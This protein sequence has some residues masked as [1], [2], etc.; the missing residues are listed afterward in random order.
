VPAGSI[1]E[2]GRQARC[3]GCGHG[4]HAFAPLDLGAAAAQPRPAPAGTDPAPRPDTSADAMAPGA[5]EEAHGPAAPA[6]AAPGRRRQFAE[7]RG[8]LDDV[9]S[10]DDAAPP[11]AKG[12]AR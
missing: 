1:G 12:D 7:I 9:Q 6:G 2:N 10:G 4:W 11:A 3:T 8:M 5:P